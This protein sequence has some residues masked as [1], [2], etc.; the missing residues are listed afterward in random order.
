L[1]VKTRPDCA[2]AVGSLARFSSNHDSSRIEAVNEL[3]LYHTR[4]HAITYYKDCNAMPNEPTAWEASSHPLDWKRTPAKRLS[5]FGDDVL[6]KRSTLGEI[7]QYGN[8]Q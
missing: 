6:T 2:F 3:Y 5:S 8:V 1:E 4:N 7:I